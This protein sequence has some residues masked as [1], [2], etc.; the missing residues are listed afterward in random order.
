METPKE[1]YVKYFSDIK[2]RMLLT[3]LIIFGAINLGTGVFGFDFIKIFSNFL[4]NLIK[5]NYPIDKV[6]YVLIAL[7]AIKLATDKNTWLPFLGKSVLPGHLL[8]IHTPEN[9][10][11]SIT[12]KVQPNKKIAYWAAMSSGEQPDV[13]QAYGDYSNSGVVMSDSE[14]IAVL[15]FVE[16]SGY[17]V[18]NGRYIKK[19]VHYRE[20]DLP[21]GLMGEIKSVEY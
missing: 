9:T 2:L 12:I 14:G 10:N 5:S 15:K 7:S 3:G 6:I 19:H 20:L 18:P 16:G 11:K 8:S 4:N 17:V 13:L 21:Y 1:S